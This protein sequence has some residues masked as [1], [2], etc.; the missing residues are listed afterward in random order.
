MA[1]IAFL[2]L[3]F[4]LV[5]SII[6]NDE[7]I[8]RTLPKKCTDPPCIANIEERNVLRIELN[9]EGQLLANNVLIA[10]SDLKETLVNFID[11][12]GDE[13]CRYCEGE[14][15]GNSSDNPAKAIISLQTDRQ[16]RYKD[17]ISVQVELNKAYFELREHYISKTFEGKQFSQLTK[18]EIKQVRDAYPLLISEAELK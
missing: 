13:S 12:N 1:D 11:N 4:F 10:F 2:L 9:K 14:S 5:T 7:G 6:P 3:I 18:E 17:F 15:L 8:L 16:S